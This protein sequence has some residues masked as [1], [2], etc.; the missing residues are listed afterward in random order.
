MHSSQL[1][2]VAERRFG[3]SPP[4]HGYRYR[5]ATEQGSSLHKSG[6]ATRLEGLGD[7]KVLNLNSG[8][9]FVTIITLPRIQ[10]I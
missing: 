2:E 3:E 9:C 7:V 4:V 8:S 1:T 5:G 10:A 6:R